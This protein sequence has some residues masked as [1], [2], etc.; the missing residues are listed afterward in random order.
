MRRDHGENKDLDDCRPVGVIATPTND[1]NGTSLRSGNERSGISKSS[2]AGSCSLMTSRDVAALLAMI[3]DVRD[4]S[5][6]TGESAD[7]NQ[8]DEN[9]T[10]S[11]AAGCETSE[12]GNPSSQRSAERQRKRGRK[13]LWKDTSTGEPNSRDSSPQTKRAKL[14]Y[15]GERINKS[16]WGK[17]QQ[18]FRFVRPQKL[19]IEE[20]EMEGEMD[21]STDIKISST[22]QIDDTRIESNS[23]GLLPMN[24]IIVSPY[25]ENKS[26][27]IG[28]VPLDRWKALMNPVVDGSDEPM[29]PLLS[30]LYGDPLARSIFRARIEIASLE[31][32]FDTSW[33][34]G[35]I[36]KLSLGWI[37]K[38]QL[39]LC[40]DVDKIR[41]PTT[42]ATPVGK[43]SKTRVFELK[44]SEDDKESGESDE[45]DASDD[46][47]D[48]EDERDA[49]IE[50]L[51]KAA[52]K[53]E[54]FELVIA[55]M[56]EWK[57]KYEYAELYSC[58]EVGE[59][60]FRNTNDN[61]EKSSGTGSN[62]NQAKKNCFKCL[63]FV[64]RA[65]ATL[66]LFNEEKK[67][68]PSLIQKVRDCLKI[69]NQHAKAHP[70]EL[71]R[72]QKKKK[73]KE[74]GSKPNPVRKK[75]KTRIIVGNCEEREVTL[76]N[77]F[78]LVKRES[79]TLLKM[80]DY[81]KARLVLVSPE[82]DS[83]GDEDEHSN[84]HFHR[85]MSFLESM[86]EEIVSNVKREYARERSF[87]KKLALAKQK[88]S[89]S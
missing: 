59:Y 81:F 79:E 37:P 58:K 41:S 28:E 60:L 40:L 63:I 74:E 52:R 6:D 14:D 42:S 27:E 66:L 21:D 86:D 69:M 10:N 24:Q 72:I 33:K 38:R 15:G 36:G 70:T 49:E 80:M 55:C 50:A 29:N 20:N 22:L 26:A 88:R 54:C 7:M 75:K 5:K 11:Q 87:R 39:L 43:K 44:D 82:K 23:G 35:K 47:D 45:T 78:A 32:L 57:L 46:D 19:Y 3:P 71:A 68:P 73:R 17:L 31:H 76:V 1:R 83:D 30:K 84:S 89:S 77:S 2:V 64:A 25:E 56:R 53:L 61:E 12:A 85:H 62:D 4:K 13:F 51:Q 16:N 34:Y 67:A 18:L 9:S 65:F 48:G 8:T